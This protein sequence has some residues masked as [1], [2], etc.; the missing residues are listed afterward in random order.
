MFS[1]LPLI[2]DAAQQIEVY[3]QALSV[4]EFVQRNESKFALISVKKNEIESLFQLFKEKDVTF[5][6][7]LSCYLERLLFDLYFLKSK[8]DGNLLL[9]PLMKDLLVTREIAEEF[10][11]DLLFLLTIFVGP[12]TGINW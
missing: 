10:G 5:V 11:E 9:L 12:P 3:F 8:G 4:D 1:A 7:I 6:A 2:W